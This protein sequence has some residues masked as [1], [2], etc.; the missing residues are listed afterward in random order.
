MTITLNTSIITPE[1]AQQLL[2]GLISF[3]QQS[4][5]S[6]NSRGEFLHFDGAEW[7]KQKTSHWVGTSC[8]ELFKESAQTIEALCN[9]LNG[10]SSESFDYFHKRYF[11][12]QLIPFRENDQLIG[13]TGFI[14]DITDRKQQEIKLEQREKIFA[15]V[16]ESS[17]DGILVTSE[18][19]KANHF[20]PTFQKIFDSQNENFQDFSPDQLREYND[21]FV[22]N[23]DEFVQNIVA[24]R[25]TGKQQKGLLQFRDGRFYEWYGVTVQMGTDKTE[26]ARIWT[27]HD[28]T[29]QRRTAEV[30]RQ[31]EKQYRSLF[32]SMPIGF[33]LFKIDY[34]KT[35]QA[36]NLRCID[37][38]P[39]MLS[40]NPK[41]RE[42]LL[43][44]GPYDFFHPDAKLISHDLGD[45]WPLKILQRT[46]DGTQNSYLT[47][48]PGTDGYY[49]LYV[50]RSQP[51]QVG[52]FV[53]NVTTLI[54]SEQAVRAKES[55]LNKILE[56]S[57]DGIIATQDS[58]TISHTN[59][60][61]L[62]LLSSLSG[63]DFN[64][65]PLTLSHLQKIFS[66]IF[67]HP[68]KFLEKIQQF[69]KN[70]RP[71]DG[72][73][74]TH[75]NR[76]LKISMHAVVSADTG[77]YRIW[78]CKEIT[79]EWYAA[80]KLK[81]NEEQYR[82]LFTSMTGTVILLNIVWNERREP[83]DFYFADVNPNFI[84]MF[85]TVKEQVIGQSFLEFCKDR[86]IQVL[87]HDFGE[88]WWA[89]LS[90]AA[91]GTSGNYHVVMTFNKEL[92]Y[93]K[94]VIFPS[95]HQVGILLYDETAEV[96]SERSLRAMQLAIDHIS[97]PVLWISWEGKII[98]ANE[99]GTTFLGF[100]SNELLIGR[101]IWEFDMNVTS[102]SWQYFL[103]NFDEDKTKQYETRM[104]TVQQECIP[105]LLIIDLLEQ[106]GEKFFATCFHDLSE[107]IKRI[108]AEQASVA[109]TKFLA[110]MSHE[111]R[112]P[113]NGVIGMSDLLLGTDL[114]PKQREYAELACISGR[115][116]L[117]L[118]NDI[119]DF[120]KIEAGKLEIEYVE[121]D[122][123]ELI[124]S[125][126]GIVAARVQD[127]DLE[128]CGLF[129][130]DV[131]RRVVGDSGRIRQILINLLSNAVKFT[132]SGGVRLVIA[133][134]ERKEIE[135]K[136]YCMTRFEVTDSGI[137]IPKERM[138]RLFQSFSQIDSSQARKYG[139]TGLGLAI[140]K[141]LVHL[142]GGKI[143]VE[144]EEN[145]GSTFWFRIP[146]QCTN[147]DA[148]VSSIFR[149]GHLELVNI[150]A[151]VVDENEVLRNVVR[152]QMET[153]GMKIDTFSNRVQALNAL[154]QAVQEN[155]P[156]RIAVID[157]R[158]DDGL[159]AQLVNNIKND[160]QLKHTAVIML[161][162][163]SEDSLEIQ[164]EHADRYVNK[165]VF[166]SALFNAIIGIL[167]GISDS[168]SKQNTLQRNELR[169]EWAEDQ[170]LKRILNS[171]SCEGSD[172]IN[173]LSGENHLKDCPLIL[174][175]ED[176]R[177]NQIVVGEILT[178][179]GYRF[180]LVGNGK[181][182]CEAVKNQKFALILMDCQMPEMDGFQ[183]TRMIR[184]M[185]MEMETETETGAETNQL[186]TA[187]NGRIPII[188]LTA[189]A[190]LGD[191][192]LCIEAGMD[193][194]CSKPI[195]AL[196]LI[197]VIKEK[198]V[199]S[200]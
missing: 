162:P 65:T 76:V 5:F 34:D 68:Q 143:G 49:T 199:V 55:L 145:R 100:Q 128:L 190:T 188:A 186:K 106:N 122:L 30:L 17:C 104:R 92:R 102:E 11:H 53:M 85:Q 1:I 38:N 54:R 173:K 159:G 3:P 176:N 97:E 46:F 59:T 154:R 56:T 177:V 181:K 136:L 6:I 114:N 43:G 50:F 193:A 138:N 96:L 107:Q 40:M 132:S 16:L 98:Y 89:G 27:F 71:F 64:K 48:D 171:F 166:G 183:A 133:V 39:A 184:Q 36:I 105:V 157:Y 47:Y 74:K 140:S 72:I 60:R 167:T 79:E 83:I 28:V 127:N 81:E 120:S 26:I 144:S 146:L 70:N 21:R 179:A 168:P 109:K 156:Y 23:T 197:E 196:K 87:S 160:P 52:V 9:A 124:E 170:S 116:L 126:L 31:S 58:G 66:K 130:T 119:L 67:E 84:E 19:G 139:G 148:L 151:L 63:I 165:P 195:N 155:Q 198:L 172:S 61:S 14:R 137:G 35:N 191:Q 113:L 153:W 57:E 189:N 118:I 178:Q 115:Y 18:S 93:Y 164:K 99:A 12:F 101:E 161:V 200:S 86:N 4:I 51:E 194:Y 62:H 73:F 125:V 192:E 77:I 95:R 32:N 82:M 91:M 13:V 150:R 180:E 88:I 33:L 2:K 37:L 45:N 22:I 129:L 10:I 152:H 169:K 108:E 174:V 185:E 134:E 135:E 20:N 29:E 175:A 163:L 25:N 15:A 80:E 142:M 94:T 75:D 121:F 147:D 117:S 158:L 41:T 78:R 69:Q 110:H 141:E 103:D 187:H 42:E 112:T 24:L 131:P 8:F 182:A 149:H 111:I 90:A 123:P 44:G 7:D